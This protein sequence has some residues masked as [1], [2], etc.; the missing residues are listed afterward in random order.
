MSDGLRETIRRAAASPG[1]PAA[2]A[3]NNTAH[4]DA[5]L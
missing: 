1:P 2:A 3:S 5:S 4:I